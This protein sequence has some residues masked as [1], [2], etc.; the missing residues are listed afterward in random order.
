ML[1][2]SYLLCL[3]PLF[4]LPADKFFGER[5]R[6]INNRA[7]LYAQ[8]LAATEASYFLFACVHSYVRLTFGHSDGFGAF[9]H[10]SFLFLRITHQ[11]DRR[12]S[13]NSE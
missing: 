5:G 4:A 11:A 10:D 13:K 9:R 6:A 7:I 12:Q 8:C 3:W 2:L 1:I